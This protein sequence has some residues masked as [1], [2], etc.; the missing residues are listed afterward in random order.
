L[1]LVRDG[2]TSGIKKARFPFRSHFL[3]LKKEPSPIYRLL[4]RKSYY[5]QQPRA[6]AQA[7]TQQEITGVQ[8]GTFTVVWTGTISQ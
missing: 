4:F 1:A 3:A 6:G 5:L 7:G 8:T 2:G